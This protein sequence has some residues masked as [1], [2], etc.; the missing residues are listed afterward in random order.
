MYVQKKKLY[1]CW[2]KTRNEIFK[3]LE[4]KYTFIDKFLSDCRTAMAAK[5]TQRYIFYHKR[6]RQTSGQKS[7]VF[8][9]TTIEAIIIYKKL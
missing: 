8:D 5:L 1:F 2:T 7:P 6:V 4:N 9:A 3:M